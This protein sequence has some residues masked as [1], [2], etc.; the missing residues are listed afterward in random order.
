M[1]VGRQG[2]SEAGRQWRHLIR[3][4]H[5][6]PS[7]VL[8]R[9]LLQDGAGAAE[10]LH[11]GFGWNKTIT[12]RKFPVS[13]GC[14]SP[15]VLTTGEQDLWFWP[16]CLSEFLLTSPPRK[17][18]IHEMKHVREHRTCTNS[19]VLPSQNASNNGNVFL[20][21]GSGGLKS[22]ISPSR[23]AGYLLRSLLGFQTVVFLLCPH[24]PF[25]CACLVSNFLFR[26]HQSDCR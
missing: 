5:R 1:V 26:G 18:G 19:V 24:A 15:G 10:F 12:V 21:D 23:Q 14:L 7:P 4:R 11:A 17:S 16:L 2:G 22:K 25:P 9:S 20:T 6:S 8:P 13:I 3:G